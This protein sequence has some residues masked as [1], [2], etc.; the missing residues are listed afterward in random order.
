MASKLL[1]QRNSFSMASKLH[2][3]RNTFSMA[4]NTPPPVVLFGYD[5][6]P[7]TQ[8][9]KLSLRLKQIPYTFITVPSMMPRPIIKDSFGVTYRKIPIMLIGRD[10]YCDTSIILEALEQTFPSPTYPSLYPKGADGRTNRSLIRGFA[11]YWTDVS[12]FV[13]IKNTTYPTVETLLP[14]HDRPN[15]LQR[16]ANG[17]RQRQSRS[18]RPQA[19]SR[20]IGKQSAQEPV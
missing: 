1:F 14:C 12:S 16:L 11:S 8:K 6:S 17:F 15:T 9:V 13:Q 2:L 3:K 20:Q 5:S 7:F 18:D 10:L 4:S 19:R